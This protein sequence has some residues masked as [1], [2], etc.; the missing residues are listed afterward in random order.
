MDIIFIYSDISVHC[1]LSDHSVMCEFILRKRT[2]SQDEGA[3]N[4]IPDYKSHCQDMFDIQEFPGKTIEFENLLNCGS[5]NTQSCKW[6]LLLLPQNP[7]WTSQ[8]ASNAIV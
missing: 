5:R 4:L 3:S 8:L 2:F 1:C 6:N 7:K